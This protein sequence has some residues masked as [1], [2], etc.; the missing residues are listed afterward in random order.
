MCWR[1][2]CF[3]LLSTPWLWAQA[4]ASSPAPSPSPSQETAAQA[5]S[6]ADAAVTALKNHPDIK[7]AQGVLDQAQA[8]IRTAS[9]PFYPRLTGGV[10]FSYSEAQSVAVAGQNVVRTGGIRN[11]SIS[12]SATQTLTDFGRTLAAVDAADQNKLSAEWQKTDAIQQLLLNVSVNYFTVLR[13]LQ[14]VKINTDNV[15]NAEVQVGRAKGFFEAGSRAKIEVIRAES[16]LAQAKLA[17]ISA[18]NNKLKAEA[19]FVNSLGLQQMVDYQLIDSAL[20]IPNWTRDE[21]I[22]KAKEKHPTLQSAFARLKAAEARLR[23]AEAAYFPSL[24]ARYSYS[25]GDQVFI[26]QPYN[27]NVGLSLDVPLWNEPLLS[28]GVQSAEASRVQAEG[29]QEQIA[30]QVMQGAVEAWLALQESRSR[31]EAANAALAAAEEAYRLASERYQVGVGASLE[32]SD[33]QRLL[34]QARSQAVQAR[35]D[36]QLAIARLYRTGGDLTLETLLPK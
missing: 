36:V 4:P 8:A 29:A 24:N 27:W 26:P 3:L 15:R 5:L 20:S 1:R 21:A 17:L 34:I 2:L 11:Y 33:A 6:L 23:N 16:D 19:A 10:G 35:F 22:S 14:D 25:W 31:T 7:V 13:A 9:A 12:V 32:V 30:L 18:Q 28:A